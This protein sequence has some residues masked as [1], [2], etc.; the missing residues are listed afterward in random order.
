M[1]TPLFTLRAG[2]ALA[3]SLHGSAA[4]SAQTTPSAKPSAPEEPLTLSI[5]EVTAGTDRGYAASTAM[6]G[7]RTNEK[8]ENLPNA[9]SVMTSDLLAD[10]GALNFLDAADFATG[11]ENI[12]NDGGTRG[13]AVGTRSGN[14]ISFRGLP[15]VR[16]LRDGFPWYMPQ[17]VFNTER[18]EFSRGPG[19]LSYGDVDAGGTVNVGTKRPGF[20]RTA[21]SVGTR[22]DSWGGRRVSLDDQRVIVPKKVALRLNAL[23][24]DGESFRER[25]GSRLNGIAGTL[26]WNISPRTTLDLM[27]ERVNEKDGATHA[28]LTDDSTVYVRGTGTLALDANPSL[29]GVQASGVGTAPISAANSNVQL[30]TLIGGKLYNLKSTATQ[31]FRYS[32]INNGAALSVLD[33]N[34]LRIPRLSAPESLVPRYQDWGGPMNYADLR[35]HTITAEVRHDFHRTLR[36]LFAVNRQVDKNVRPKTLNDN[37]QA[38]F[39]GRGIFI[40][41]NPSI[42]DVSNPVAPQLAPNPYYEKHYIQHQ[43]LTT[44]DG[45]DIRNVRAVLVYD[46]TLP[47]GITQRAV[48][49]HGFRSEKY[50]KDIFNESLSLAEIARRGLTGTQALVTNNLVYRHHYLVDGNRD[51]ALSNHPIAGLETAF[52]RRDLLGTNARYDQNLANT[53]L[54]LLGGYFKD[55]LRTSIGLSRDRWHQ[56]IARLGTHAATGIRGFVDA[57]GAVLPEGAP[58]PV[59]D[60]NEQWVTNQSYGAVLRVLPWLS[61]TGAWLESRQFSDNLGTDLNGRPYPGLGGKGV[62]GGARLNFLDGRITVSYVRFNTVGTN[63]AVGISTA[64]RDELIPFNARPFTG[65]ND[66]RDRKTSGHEIEAFFSPTPNLT[67]RLSYASSLVRFTNFYPLLTARYE[68]AVA[69]AKARGLNPATLFPATDQFFDDAVDLNG[70]PR[71]SMS[72]TGRYSVTDGALRGFALGC[73]ARYQQ[74]KAIAGI[75]VAGVQVIP[76]KTTDDM[77]VFSPFASY[78]HKFGRVSWTGQINVQNIFDRVSYQGLNYRNNRLTEPRQFVLTNTLG[79]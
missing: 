12:F 40:D 4:T 34:P 76:A 21:T 39:G 49:S 71:H 17:D 74:G 45:H 18:I 62:D 13:A 59:F 38:S 43:L 44:N 77:Y 26:R 15:S 56:K 66:Y 19:G 3:A 22:W 20:G 61:F 10:L 16:Q 36:G 35:W 78:R 31:T 9:I 55:R 37:L 29:A 72:F 63:V 24:N 67:G 69:T 6:S 2:L 7:T 46:P 41:V 25:G 30:F 64:A 73:N 48:L 65:L 47:W 42:I 8:L 11:A 1:H 28:L 58:I 32:Q 75:S 33:V 54:N 70:T 53:S 60:I 14:Q 50:Y 52:Y 27:W 51:E 79:F 57:N 68:E 5:F 23:Y